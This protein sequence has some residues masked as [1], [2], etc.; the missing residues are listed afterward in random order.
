VVA[1]AIAGAL[2]DR[3]WLLGWALLTAA[4]AFGGLILSYSGQ[5]E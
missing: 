4:F 5:P 3:N 1:P 2:I